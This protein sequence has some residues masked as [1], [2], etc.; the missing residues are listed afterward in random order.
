MN[1]W[2]DAWV[3]G[4]A[5]RFDEEHEMYDYSDEYLDY[6]RWLPYDVI[7]AASGDIMDAKTQKCLADFAGLPGKTVILGPVI[8]RC[9]RALKSCEI[10]KHMVEEGED[11]GILFAEEPGEIG[12]GFWEQLRRSRE[13]GCGDLEIELAVHRREGSGFHLLYI[14]NLSREEKTAFIT[15]TGGR[16]FSVLQGPAEIK[17]EKDGITVQIPGYTAAILSVE[18]NV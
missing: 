9:D 14:A 8:P 2:D 13:Y 5:K 16:R 17:M 10:L 4:L 1:Y 6:D 3:K 11:S 18:E 12:A 7:A 15:C